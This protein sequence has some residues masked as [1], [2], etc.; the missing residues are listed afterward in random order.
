[1]KRLQIGLVIVGFLV[2]IGA[3]FGG[4]EIGNSI[5]FKDEMCRE[6]PC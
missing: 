3:I 6:S 1:M 4:D 5:P 2:V